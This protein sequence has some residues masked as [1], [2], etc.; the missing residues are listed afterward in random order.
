MLTDMF[1]IARHVGIS[2]VILAL[3]LMNLFLC[4]F[5]A[6]PRA[7]VSAS[8]ASIMQPGHFLHPWTALADGEGG[9]DPHGCWPIIIHALHDP[10]RCD[11]N[12]TWPLIISFAF[13]STYAAS[14][15]CESSPIVYLVVDGPVVFVHFAPGGGG[16]SWLV[17]IHTE[18]NLISALWWCDR[19][20]GN[21]LI[22]LVV[23]IHSHALVVPPNLC[24][25]STK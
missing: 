21:G 2:R 5:L 13:A 18:D 12:P 6:Q 25:L 11:R 7:L 16:S 8:I 22:V 24:R 9:G 20:P 14:C 19:N 15:V 10:R 1:S 17:I 23:C 4:C 3:L